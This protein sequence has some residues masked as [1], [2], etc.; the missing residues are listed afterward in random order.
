MRALVVMVALAGVAAAFAA[1]TG[2]A[3]SAHAESSKA[4]AARPRLPALPAQI[5]SRGRFLIGVKC[6][7]PPFGYIRRGTNAGYDVDVARRFAQLAFGNRSRV[8]LTCTT[9]QS[10]I[11][12]LTSQRVDIIISTL[13]WTAER[14]Q[15]IDYSIP[16]Y[17]AAGRLLVRNNVNLGRLRT[18][19]R[20][21]TVV[22]TPGSIYDRWIT[23]CFKQ[24]RLLVI[25]G[26]SNGVLAVKDGRADAMMYD[27]AF[28]VGVAA[29]DRELKMTNHK[30]LDIPWGVGIR[31]GDAAT[32]RWVDAAI[33]HMTRRDE[34]WRIM[35]RTVPRRFYAQFRRNV[36]R[37]KVTLRY[38]RGTTP[39]SRCPR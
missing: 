31:K 32:K 18:A 12:T 10:R 25:S 33:R 22:T 6:D 23:N 17:G 20:D 30:F 35:R 11:P 37:P 24:T 7:T 16:Y 2:A 39:E 29:T 14:E 26:P 27:D 21:K 15:T 28:L 1:W 36:P 13:T 9:T 34:F 19:L 8:D 4:D 3:P 5:R 38:P